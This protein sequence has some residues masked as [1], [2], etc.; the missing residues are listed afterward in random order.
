MQACLQTARRALLWQSEAL[1]H[2]WLELASR[3]LTN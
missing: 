1:R 2:F 3:L